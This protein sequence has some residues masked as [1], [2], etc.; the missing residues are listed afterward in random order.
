MNHI[1]LSSN[2]NKIKKMY[3]FSIYWIDIKRKIFF[4]DRYK[5]I[6]R[7]NNY[8]YLTNVRY[9]LGSSYNGKWDQWYGPSGRSYNYDIKSIIETCAVAKALSNLGIKLIPNKILEL[10]SMATIHCDLEN[11]TNETNRTSF[12]NPLNSSCL[13]NIRQD[14]CEKYNLANM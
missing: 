2:L 7:H 14:P 3:I 6:K 13:I 5:L 12:C 11:R 9:I 8:L 4:N 10:R 1:T